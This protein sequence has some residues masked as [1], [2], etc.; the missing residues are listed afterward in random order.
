MCDCVYG[1]VFQMSHLYLRALLDL[2]SHLEPSGPPDA[3]NDQV[4]SIL[5]QHGLGEDV[6]ASLDPDLPG[7]GC[8][9]GVDGLLD[10]AV[11]AL[12]VEIYY[13]CDRFSCVIIH[14][15]IP[16]LIVDLSWRIR[17]CEGHL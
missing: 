8:G 6:L 15:I 13:L 3:T 11:V 1:A 17:L 7:V 5:H 14:E 10:R 4:L 9:Q 16:V 2:V 12:P